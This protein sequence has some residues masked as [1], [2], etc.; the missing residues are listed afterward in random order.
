LPSS[1]SSGPASRLFPSRRFHRSLRR[2]REATCPK[3]GE[4]PCKDR[5]RM[6]ADAVRW[7]TWGDLRQTQQ[8]PF[9]QA[10][11]ACHQR[12]ARREWQCRSVSKALYD[13]RSTA[14]ATAR[15]S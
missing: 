10:S 8:R 6:S 9:H 12:F 11:L 7:L 2:Q 13:I 4:N 15:P 14:A 5:V 3:A 1:P